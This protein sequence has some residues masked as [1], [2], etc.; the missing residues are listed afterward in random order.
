MEEHRRLA[1]GAVWTP[2][3]RRGHV[4]EM[5]FHVPAYDWVF[6]AVGGVGFSLIGLL[7]ARRA[8]ELPP[9]RA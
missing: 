4:R 9:P 5:T 8:R 6:L 7:V 1:F 2:G 3:L